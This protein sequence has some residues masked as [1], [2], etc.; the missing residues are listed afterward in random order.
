MK[1]RNTATGKEELLE[2]CQ[3]ASCELCRQ[4]G[5]DIYFE[6]PLFLVVQDNGE[7][8]QWHIIPEEGER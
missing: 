1:L 3:G 8:E 7:M 4:I 6:F 2:R 5:H